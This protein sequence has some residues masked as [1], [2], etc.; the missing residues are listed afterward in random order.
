MNIFRCACGNTVYFENDRCLRCGER[1]GFLPDR[2]IQATLTSRD[3]G[4]WQAATPE[5]EVGVYRRCRN[6]EEHNVCNW[7]VPAKSKDVFCTACRLNRIIP[8][9]DKPGNREKWLNVEREKRRL[10]YELLRLGLPFEAKRDNPK[11]GL[12]FAFMEDA[13]QTGE[14]VNRNLPGGR[15]FTGHAGGLITINIIEAD[16]AA[17]EAMRQQLNEASRT[18]LGHFRH[19][20]GHYYWDRLI[21][22]DG[23]LESF[24][25]AFGD[26]RQDY[27]ASLKRHYAEGPPSDWQNCFISGYA[28]AH[29]WEDWAECWGHYLQILDALETAQALDMG[30]KRPRDFD[31]LIETWTRVSISVNLMN[32]SMGMRDA[33]PFVLN[34]PVTEK[35]RYIHE[36]IGTVAD[37]ATV[38]A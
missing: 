19:E 5:G 33:Y 20:I 16:D 26:E 13:V 35:I 6:N 14:F 3:D 24:R 15:V 38:P 4:T 27:Q 18:L 37:P 9:L 10:I 8:N 34:D 17:R 2:L 23:R 32:R 7:M 22:D 29:A 36:L 11:E 28:T 25:A 12:A 30:V 1:L 31:E 21:R